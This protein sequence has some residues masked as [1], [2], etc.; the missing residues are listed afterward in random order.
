MSDYPQV[1]PIQ[2]DG[3]SDELVQLGYT[4]AGQ[5]NRQAGYIAPPRLSQAWGPGGVSVATFLVGGSSKQHT[6]FTSWSAW[7]VE[8]CSVYVPLSR[9]VC[10]AGRSKYNVGGPQCR[11][12]NL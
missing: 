1:N 4:P 9:V 5:R 8:T 7:V 12:L 3:L 6:I 10:I 2:T 11:T